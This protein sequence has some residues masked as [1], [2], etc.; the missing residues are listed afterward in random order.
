MFHHLSLVFVETA[1]SD[2]QVQLLA[3]F[4]LVLSNTVR[5]PACVSQNATPFPFPII[6]FDQRPNPPHVKCKSH[7]LLCSTGHFQGGWK[8]SLMAVLPF[9]LAIALVEQPF[10]SIG[11][12]Y[13]ILERALPLVLHPLYLVVSA[14]DGVAV[15]VVIVVN[16]VGV[17]LRII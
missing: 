6:S 10:L 9:K 16:L 3:H 5:H 17:V 7:A 14:E 2:I 11:V 12:E 4:N 1:N 8:H 13:T 15:V